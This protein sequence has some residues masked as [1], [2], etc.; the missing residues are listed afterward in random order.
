MPLLR[1]EDLPPPLREQARA[2][3]GVLP[4]PRET[5]GP[6]KYRNQVVE[7]EGERFGSKWELRRY[8][9][10]LEQQ[11][12]GLIGELR[13]HVA[14]AL[15]VRTPESELVR[16]ASYEA[17]F[18]YRRGAELVVEDTKS[19]ATRRKESY[20]LKASHFEAEYGIHVLDV[21]RVRRKR[22]DREVRG[23]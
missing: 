10:L 15:H 8:Q 19:E 2:Q 18:T 12:A 16:I 14:F 7:F 5:P 23:D 13:H 20:R 22:R 21:V 11:A 1:L 6:A 17:D 9:E 4:A 3:L